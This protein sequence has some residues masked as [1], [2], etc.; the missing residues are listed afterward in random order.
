MTI[1]RTIAL[2]LS[3][4]AEDDAHAVRKI[5]ALVK[6]LL[7]AWG[8]KCDSLTWEGEDGEV[9]H[10][11]PGLLGPSGEGGPSAISPAEPHPHEQR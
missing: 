3:F 1:K 2:R 10:A 11:A 7:R 5:R 8:L 9:E 6:W 4:K